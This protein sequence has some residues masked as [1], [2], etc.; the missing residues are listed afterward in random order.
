[1]SMTHSARD[2][3]SDADQPRPVR[4][5]FRFWSLVALAA[6]IAGTYFLLPDRVD[7]AAT[8][9]CLA[10]IILVVA[11]RKKAQSATMPRQ[12]GIPE[13][14]SWG[15]TKAAFAR[16]ADGLVADSQRKQQPFTIVVL[17]QSD[18]PELS[19]IF[20]LDAAQHLVSKMARTLQNISPAKGI[21]VRTDATVFTVL[22]PGFSRPMASAALKRA[23]GETFSIEC[24]AG[25]EEIV[26]VPDFLIRTLDRDSP[27]VAQVYAQM[28]S[29]ITRARAQE[30]RRHL[31]LRQEHESHCTKPTPLMG[32]GRKYEA[33]APHEQ[34]IAMPLE[35]K[36]PA[37]A[38]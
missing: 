31:Y 29:A 38:S 1:M 6:A 20:G 26:L 18:L 11:K 33:Y 3:R 4:D 35:S 13:R 27:P 23:L 36:R 7:L 14:K 9:G 2:E 8:V 5:G 21:V 32:S 28:C 12:S 37:M 25:D 22:L 17:E 10:A 19:A 30:E 34:T 15:A 16:M 24:D